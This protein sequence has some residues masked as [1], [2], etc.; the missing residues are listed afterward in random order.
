MSRATNLW[1]D[2]PV[3][4][5]EIRSLQI[6]ALHFWMAGARNEVRIGLE[7][8]ASEKR[9][10]FHEEELLAPAT[11]E[12]SP[13][14]P[15]DLTW[16]RFTFPS[17]PKRLHVLPAPP[18]RPLILAATPP[19]DL[20]PGARVRIFVALPTW[21]SLRSP[22]DREAGVPDILQEVPVVTLSSTWFGNFAEGE[23]CYWLPTGAR[24]EV[25]E[26]PVAPHLVT[27]PIQVANRSE[28]SL[29]VD[30]L[31]L[32]VVYATV[33]EHQGRLW[34]DENRINYLGGG[35]FSR[36]HWTGQ[37]PAEAPGATLLTPPRIPARTG[38]TAWTFE[39]LREI[40][41]WGGR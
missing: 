1:G 34:T 24:S 29:L 23:M 18:D 36:I 21:V 15:E 38:F 9:A 22:F 27:C 32:R 11:R 31:C 3:P 30:K 13:E 40:P 35:D 12:A 2:Q 28:E 20:R 41:G 10:A 7:R 5:R 39:R 14:P 4:P 8:L 25:G 33:F 26:V 37:A 17:S 19:L 6:G 16:K